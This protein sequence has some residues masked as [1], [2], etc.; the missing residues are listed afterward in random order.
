MRAEDDRGPPPFPANVEAEQSLLGAL[1][2]W[3]ESHARVAD[4]LR[5]EDFSLPVHQRIYAAV[6]AAID[7]GRVANPVTLSDVFARDEALV[8]AGGTVYLAQLAENAVT[9]INARHYAEQIVDLARRRALIEACQETLAAAQ[10]VS[11]DR[12]VSMVIDQHEQRLYELGERAPEARVA[13]M[14]AAARESIAR[15]EAVYRAGGAIQGVETG[16]ADLDRL[17]GGL[18]PGNLE[19]VAGR[20]SMGKSALAGGIAHY[21]ASRGMPV[22]LFSLEETAAQQAQRI[23]AIESG[24]A[25]DRQRRGDLD[26]VH[27]QSIVDAEQRIG[28]LPIYID[29]TPGQ[30]VPQLR[31]RMRDLVRRQGVRL[32][33]V[34][35]LQ[36]IG[37][38]G[39]VESRRVEV[40]EITRT[41]K[42]VAKELGIPIVL[43]SQLS[44]A[45]EARDNKRPLLSDLRESG[46]IESDADRVIFVYR[47][48]YY[49]SRAEPERR[50]EEPQDRFNDRHQRWVESIEAAAGIADLILAKNRF[51]PTGSIK[52]HWDAALTRF[53]NL[54][55]W[56]R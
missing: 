49:L 53:S 24:V 35:H 9:I 15:T 47:Q 48:E 37:S 16:L 14:A 21:V 25:S 20:P 11:F 51:G 8:G 52:C 56:E 54:E 27:W 26:M 29:E 33:I 3:N 44:R 45:V 2:V 10:G 12:P 41:L 38:A 32:A 5:P 19:V 39:R 17:L 6:A 4:I 55:R 31:R 42:R 18:L 43:L 50:A 36:I 34:D 1:L 7:A 28:R 30:T 40:G 22:A 23:V 46:D 13:T